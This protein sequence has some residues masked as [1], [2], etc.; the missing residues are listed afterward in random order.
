MRK[1]FLFITIVF[2]FFA[3]SKAQSL[4]N[5]SLKDIDGN[6]VNLNEIDNNSNP[7]IISFFATWCKPC[8]RELTAINEL[9]SEWQEELGVKLIAVS[10]DEGAQ[11]FKVKPL[12]KTNDWSYQVLLDSN[13]EFMRAMNV[14]MVPSIFILDKNKEIVYSHTGYIDGDENNLI[15]E[16]RKCVK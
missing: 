1:L 10:I 8:L 7:I 9:Y 11:A 6:L 3:I 2:S 13:Q 14:S 15:N 16:L 5:I 4:P 12:V